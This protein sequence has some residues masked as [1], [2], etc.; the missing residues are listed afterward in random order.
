MELLEEEV[1]S[2]VAVVR[3][4]DAEVKSNKVRKMW[5]RMKSCL[6]VDNLEYS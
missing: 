3:E 1:C 4:I 2:H 5:G 6:D